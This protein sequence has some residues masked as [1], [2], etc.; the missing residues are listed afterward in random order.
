[1]NKQQIINIF[2]N[3]A[4]PKNLSNLINK[5]PD[6]LSSSVLLPVNKKHTL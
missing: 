1:M 4:V 5:Y 6:Y 2:E 3:A